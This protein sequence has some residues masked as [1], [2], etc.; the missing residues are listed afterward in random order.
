[1]EQCCLSQPTWERAVPALP[2]LA[3]ARAVHSHPGTPHSA[4]A[5]LARRPHPPS[6]SS[7]SSVLVLGWTRRPLL[8]P[9][10]GA[11]WSPSLVGGSAGS[12][13]AAHPLP[14]RGRRRR[15][16]TGLF[17][18]PASGRP[19]NIWQPFPQRLARGS[20]L[21]FTRF[22]RGRDWERVWEEALQQSQY[23][24]RENLCAAAGRCVS[25]FGTR[26]PGPTW[27][28][29]WLY[30][31][32][33]RCTLTE[34][35]GILIYACSPQFSPPA[36]KTAQYLPFS[37]HLLGSVGALSDE[38]TPLRTAAKDLTRASLS[39]GTGNPS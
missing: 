36:T 14:R 29:P 20:Q 10:P 34:D 35:L 28:S 19:W 24:R 5:C 32:S 21:S 15:F 22:S 3:P 26:R 11:P 18:L 27:R 23:R 33:H 7:L 9:G 13:Q 30:R 12:L 37:E 4:A 8:W 38:A 17:A 25:L 6:L 16:K 31:L 39:H 1:M 2:C